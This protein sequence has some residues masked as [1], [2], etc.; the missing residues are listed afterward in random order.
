MN[1]KIN[2]IVVAGAGAGFWV[3]VGLCR[4]LSKELQ[5]KE[6]TIEV[7]DDDNLIGGT[8]FRRLPKAINESH[9][10]VDLLY[11]HVKFVMGDVPP[12]IHRRKLGRDELLIGDWT[13]TLVLDC[14]DMSVVDREKWWKTLRT[15]GARG[16]RISMD[17]TGAAVVSPGPPIVI[18]NDNLQG[19]DVPTNQGQVWRAAGQGVE[20]VLFLLATGETPEFQTFVPTAQYRTLEINQGELSDNISSDEVLSDSP[21]DS[22]P[23][24]DRAGDPGL[25][26][27]SSDGQGRMADSAFGD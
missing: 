21:E 16:L 20:A 19:Y 11:T 5:M 24:R 7:Y 18:G 8:G 6:L 12:K 1:Q 9:Y 23:D 13:T 4:A 14:T 27:G 22:G 26:V 17:G 3:V 10:K 2:R 15:S 25:L